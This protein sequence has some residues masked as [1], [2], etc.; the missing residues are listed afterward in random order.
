MSAEN[1]GKPLGGRGSARNPAAGEGD[2]CPSSRTPT[3]LRPFG[4]SPDETSLVRPCSLLYSP[5][6]DL[7]N[8]I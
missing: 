1:S 6:T 7:D 3:P 2:C 4:L 8:A 5:G